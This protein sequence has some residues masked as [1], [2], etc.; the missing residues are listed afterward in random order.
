MDFM[1]SYGNRIGFVII[2]MIEATNYVAKV[3]NNT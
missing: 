1:Q 2:Y 3:N